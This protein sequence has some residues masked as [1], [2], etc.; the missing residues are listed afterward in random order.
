MYSDVIYLIKD[1][2]T[3]DKN[4][5]G[6]PIYTPV[7]RMVFADE[8]S[9]RQSEFYQAN[10]QGLKPEL[11]YEIR[12]ADYDKEQKIKTEDGTYYDVLRTFRK[13]RD[14]IELICKGVVNRG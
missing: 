10:A 11:M 3:G 4:D 7:E 12:Y 14:Y 6:D 8:K 9:V 5:L 1:E 2:P 13:N